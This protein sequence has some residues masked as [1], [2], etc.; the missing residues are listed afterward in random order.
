M[1]NPEN[2][3]TKT[4]KNGIRVVHKQIPA[5]RVGH[6]GFVI[7]AGSRDE[8]PDAIG[9]AHF[10]E[11]MLFKG[12]Q[13]RKARQIL[14]RMDEVGAEINA[15]TTK[16]HT[17]VY[18]SFLDQHLNRAIELLCDICFHSTFPAN[19][20]VKEKKVV[21]EEYE[22][23]LDSPDESI[24]DEF[25]EL[26]FK[27]HA[28]GHN[29]LGTRDSISQFSAAQ[30][31]HFVQHNYTA[32]NLVFSST[33]NFTLQQVL[34]V[35]E[36][37]LSHI[38]F[39]KHNRSRK[40][41]AAQ[42]PFEKTVKKS[43]VQ[44]HCIMGARAYAT[45]HKNRMALLLLN[46]YLGGPALNSRLNISVREKYG[47]TYQIESSYV[48]YSDSGMFTIYLGTDPVYL[49]RCV[50]LIEKELR[51]VCTTSFSVA[52]LQA[53]KKQLIGQ[54]SIAEENRSSLMLALGKS[55]C[56]FNRVD[57]LEQLFKKVEAIT[58]QQLLET[59]NEIMPPEQL[60]KLIYLPELE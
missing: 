37:E 34:D 17:S 36:P 54:I 46:N 11:H 60:S 51:A 55:M 10:L 32:E 47:Y 26:L 57:T 30:L 38:R 2:I 31:Q 35:L 18:S 1:N 23:Y 14:N 5:T 12:T 24:Y 6:C 56:D 3:Q 39:P 33:G 16:E 41:P 43:F 19:E 50:S 29:I 59:A 15:Y 53:A 13:K 28:L 44:A 27:K 49:N 8:H 4:L 58:P 20:M 45:S 40:K 25:S 52:K 9:A 22:M 42:K 48:P 7:H 21:L